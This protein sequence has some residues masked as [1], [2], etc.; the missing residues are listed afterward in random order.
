MHGEYQ[1]C[2]GEYQACI[3]S[4]KHA[5]EYQA[6]MG[7]HCRTGRVPAGGLVVEALV[8]CGLTLGVLRGIR[9]GAGI[10]AEGSLATFWGRGSGPNASVSR[11]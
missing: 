8:V 11:R 2:M 6:C 9:G 3:E 7:V 5:S 1:A 4:T 10:F